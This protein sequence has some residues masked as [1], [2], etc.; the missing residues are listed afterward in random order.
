MPDLKPKTRADL[1]ENIWFWLA[2]AAGLMV[3]VAMLLWLFL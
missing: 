1:E 3:I 2:G